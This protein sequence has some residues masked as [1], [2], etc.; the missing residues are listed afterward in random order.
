MTKPTHSKMLFSVF[1]LAMCSGQRC[2][3]PRITLWNCRKCKTSCLGFP[4]GPPPSSSFL[5]LQP[6]VQVWWDSLL[7]EVDK[8]GLESQAATFHLHGGVTEQLTL[9][10]RASVLQTV[11]W[12]NI[13]CTLKLGTVSHMKVNPQFPLE[14]ARGEESCPREYDS[15]I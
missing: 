10:L 1:S 3:Q 11:E 8:P 14:G 4:R 15:S 9:L 6:G 7:W 5:L 2:D 12:A 13:L